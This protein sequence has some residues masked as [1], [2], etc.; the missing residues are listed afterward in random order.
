MNGIAPV[1]TGYIR[2]S[3]QGVGHLLKSA[4]NARMAEVNTLLSI[5][6]TAKTGIALAGSAGNFGIGSNINITG[7]TSSSK[8]LD[9]ATEFA[10]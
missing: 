10:M 9:V 7:Y 5:G 4:H 2:E 3:A 8:S 1:D 6:G